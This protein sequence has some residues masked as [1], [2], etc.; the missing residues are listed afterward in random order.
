MNLRNVRAW[1]TD[2]PPPTCPEHVWTGTYPVPCGQPINHAGDHG[3]PGRDYIPGGGAT[4]WVGLAFAGLALLAI[5][6]GIL[7]WLR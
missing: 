2:D 3:T 1:L 5:G 4:A 6:V 7:W